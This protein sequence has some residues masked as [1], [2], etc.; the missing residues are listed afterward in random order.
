L[1]ASDGKAELDPL[2]TRTQ[3]EHVSSTGRGLALLLAACGALAPAPLVAQTTEA[4]LEA[5]DG[6]AGDQFGYA[7]SMSGD[8]A[9]VGAFGAAPNGEYSGAAYVFDFDGTS[10]SETAKLVPADGAAGDCFGYSVALDGDRALV[11]AFGDDSE[12]GAAYVFDF[13]G[14]SWNETA[15]LVAS[16]GIA[17]DD[18]GLAVALD[19]DRVLVGAFGVEGFTGAAY[20]FDLVGGL[21][22]QSAK[23]VAADRAAGDD[24]GVSVS[25][26]GHR[27]LVGAD[28]D[29]D[30]G[31]SS[32]SAYVFEFDGFAWP[33]TAKLVPSDG[34]A[35]DLFGYS[36]AV[37]GERA[38]S[39]ALLDDDMGSASGAVYVFEFDTAAWNETKLPVGDGQAAD[40]YGVSVAVDADRIVAGA[41]GDDDLGDGAGSAYEFASDAT[42]WSEEA[43]RN[44]AA[45]LAGDALGVSVAVS[46]SH[47]LAGA[48]GATSGQGAAHVF[49]T[50]SDE[51]LDYLFLAETS[52]VITS[53]DQTVGRVHSNGDIRYVNGWSLQDGELTAVDDITIG[54]FYL[55]VGD[56]SAGGTAM[57][58]GLS[59]VVGTVTSGAP[60]APVTLPAPAFVAGGPDVSVPADGTVVLAPG[61]YDDVS[62]GSRGLLVLAHNGISGEFRFDRVDVN[63]RGIIRANVTL[64]AVTVNVAGDLAL[65]N[66]SIIERVPVSAFADEVDVNVLGNLETRDRVSLV[67]RYAVPAGTFRLGR[68]N[69][70]E[71]WVSADRIEIGSDLNA[72]APTPPAP[73]APPSA[74]AAP[75]TAGPPARRAAL[76]RRP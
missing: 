66:R 42:G 71:G 41:Y 54:A 17:S 26:E 64:G 10:W 36:V 46:G 44:A 31:P 34:S 38:V 13:D 23:L 45:G 47:V 33:E 67:G 65:A 35:L 55:I 3:I 14:T 69:A 21:W 5:S 49:S 53:Q 12:I 32:G 15:K 11:G 61:S 18:F 52:I 6:A 30:H 58:S 56:V 50:P 51:P 28:G 40:Y 2:C 16:D 74:T 76:A 57:V 60:V 4:R 24:F 25:L 37:D 20:V 1:S 75:R 70:L 73:P 8:R 9:L 48:P 63:D 43:K 72:N 39:G 27:A 29:D 59:I 7:V 68:R 19:G 62:I 22:A